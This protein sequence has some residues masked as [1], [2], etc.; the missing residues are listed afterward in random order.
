MK[1]KLTLLI[2]LISL[3][4]IIFALSEHDFAYIA[5]TQISSN[6]PYYELEIPTVVYDSIT[7]DDLGDLRV[8]NGDGH[9][10]PHGLRATAMVKNRKTEVKNM[11][12]FPLYHQNRKTATDLHLNIK[13]NAHGEVI[14]IHS[15]LPKNTTDSRLT[16]YLIDLRKWKKPV[17]KLKINWKNPNNNSFIRKLTISRSTNLERWQVISRG[18]T[19]VN[20]SYQNH[21]LMENVID[22]SA[23]KTN[24]LRILFQD[25][26]PGL[27]FESIEASHT[28]SSQHKQQNWKTVSV[29]S[30]KTA[31]EYRFQ[32]NLK[33][34]AR[35]FEIKLP[36]NN[37]VVRARISSR[38]NKETPWTFRGSALLYRLSVNG[39]NIE[40]SKINI[41][42][43]RDAEWILY[44]EQQGGGIGSGLP[45]VKLAWQPQQLVFVARGRPPYRVVWGSAQVNPVSIN[46]NQ[47]LPNI[48]SDITTSENMISTALLLSDTKRPVN[49]QALQPKA[50]EVNWRQWILWIVLVGSALLLIWVATRLMKKMADS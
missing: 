2:L 11:P 25:N 40:K 46:A 50:K 31:G 7:R 44:F 1:H 22:I 19:L 47:L 10:V 14:N 13:R 20:M 23:A 15:R 41:R 32:H 35:Q 18:K 37:T 26:K 21:Q 34:L 28:Q 17:H 12:F 4:K 27:E 36:E 48:G 43:N 16:G 6:T 45:K 24:Y 30:T 9:V 49:K 42:P 5:E 39:S 8:L 33:S 29:N 38:A 3:P